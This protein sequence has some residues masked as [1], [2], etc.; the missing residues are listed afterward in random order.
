VQPCDADQLEALFFIDNG[1]TR[2][3]GRWRSEEHHIQLDR[4][5]VHEVAKRRGAGD[6]LEIA[7]RAEHDA[8]LTAG[9]H[10]HARPDLLEE[11]GRIG[12]CFEEHVA[13]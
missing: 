3:P 1:Q 8:R 2:F 10:S 5:I 13:G 11:R 4:A 6:H 7:S 12:L 9:Q